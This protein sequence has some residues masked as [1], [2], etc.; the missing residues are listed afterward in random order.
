VSLRREFT[1]N[2]SAYASYSRGY[3]GGGFNL[4]RNF[5][6]ALA[7][8]PPGST[9]KT[10][11][12]G[13]F[14]DAFEIGLKNSLM[15]GALLLNFATFWNKYENYQLNTFNGVSFQVSSVPE[16]F[17]QG[18]ELDAIWNTPIDGLS[19][20]GGFAYVE[21]EYGDD[22]GWVAQSRN[23]LNP[24]AAPVNFRLPGSR[25]TNAPLWTVTG[26]F[27]YEKPL[28]NDAVVGLAYLD[29]RYVSDQITGSDLEPTKT[30]PGY[31]TVN[32]RIG[33]SNPSDKL[34]LEL[35]GRNLFDEE[36]QQIAFNVPLQGN[37]RGAFLGDPRTYGVTLR[38]SY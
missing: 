26:A 15:D 17:S 3:K 27:T 24:A 8:A 20:Q 1:D 5:D 23:P 30:Q 13:E 12:A 2:V 4:D 33:I 28:F 38:V 37:A 29:F 19:Y 22:S 21:A 14:V 11:F 9:W 6:F 32:G 7:T 34:S 31:V 25:L 35:W 36:Y 10:D 18:L 16:A